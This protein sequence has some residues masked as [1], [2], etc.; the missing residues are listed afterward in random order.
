[1]SNITRR[2]FVKC[3]AALTAS[4]AASSL[5]TGCNCPASSVINP[6]E[7]FSPETQVL[8]LDDQYYL[9]VS[10]T[11]YSRQPDGRLKLDLTIANYTEGAIGIFG[12]KYQLMN[13]FML[14][15]MESLSNFYVQ[16]SY[17]SIEFF[18]GQLPIPANSVKSGELIF[19]DPAS[20]AKGNTPVDEKLKNWKTIT[21]ILYLMDTQ[22]FMP[23][24][25]QIE[26]SLPHL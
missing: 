17:M 21:F 5:L 6:P 25:K 23:I 20:Y 9:A 24:A 4:A 10:T 15:D 26:F 18:Q 11:S 13:Y 3:V 2:G 12:A 14:D 22:T 19:P 8:Q 7:H 16:Q 1:M